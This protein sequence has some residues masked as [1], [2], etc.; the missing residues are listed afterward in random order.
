LEP[1]LV[2]PRKAKLMMGMINKTDK[3][4]VH[5]LNRLQRNGT[6]PTVWIPPRA[7]RDHRETTRA[8][9][10]MTAHRTRLKNRI[11]ATLSKYGWAGTEA[12]DPFGKKARKEL[13]QAIKELPPQTA[14]ITEALLEQLDFVRS[15]EV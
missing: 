13:K 6:L 4:D 9:M 7:L 12:S 10:V 5:G 11:Q 2:H 15:R 3:L 14:Y 8:R 1:K